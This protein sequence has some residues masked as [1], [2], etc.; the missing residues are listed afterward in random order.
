MP[1]RRLLSFLA[2]TVLS[3]DAHSLGIGEIVSQPRLGERLRIEVRLLADGQS[4]IEPGC[5]RLAPGDSA[6][7]LPWVRGARLRI[8]GG[9]RPTLLIESNEAINHPI[10][11]LGLRVGCGAEVKREFTLMPQAPLELP[12]AAARAPVAGRSI[13]APESAAPPASETTPGGWTTIEGETLSG[14]ASALFPNDPARQKNFIR[15]A[16]RSN[17][18]LFRGVA[19]PAQHPLPAGVEL[20][21]P[22]SASRK[23]ER[24]AA[25]RPKPAKIHPPMPAPSRRRAADGNA[26]PDAAPKSAPAPLPRRGEDRLSV[27]SGPGGEPGLKFSTLL[28]DARSRGLT[29]EQRE[30]LRQEQRL[31]AELD[32]K[33]VASLALAEKI[34]NMEGYL[35]K[36]QGDMV[37]LDQKIQ[38]AKASGAADKAA[39]N[40][41]AT[42]SA[43]PA[44]VTKAPVA[45]ES[46]ESAMPWLYLLLAAAAALVGW[47]WWRRRTGEDDYRYPSDAAAADQ[48]EPALAADAPEHTIAVPAA[49]PVAAAADSLALE[50][51][52]HDD[53]EHRVGVA[54]HDSALELAEIMLSFGRV[55]G[56]AQT[57][58]DYIHANPRQAI[59]PWLKLLEVYHGAGMRVEFEALVEQFR[60]NFNVQQIAWDDYTQDLA[61]ASLEDLPH[62]IG[63]VVASWGTAGCLKLLQSHLQDNREGT[64]AGFPLGVVDDIATLIALLEPRLAP[65]PVMHAQA[66]A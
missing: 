49:A 65:R 15:E 7:D 37:R 36:L 59:R 29:E 32:D 8:Q 63:E 43:A 28:D 21:L 51:D 5:I 57:L 34:R 40:A 25:A 19:E 23:T 53:A 33:I 66:A 44:G 47:L 6:D 39:P 50:L 48:A 64:R 1:R 41:P 16:A 31:I 4:P 3:V 13:S 54:E 27:A 52:D 18:R 38:S 45:R 17:P 24:T 42:P 30:R 61:R 62:L 14:I 26:P 35:D 11:L 10:Y 9:P 60:R 12:V 58:S 20:A 22:G 56:A 46:E 55:Q 2:L